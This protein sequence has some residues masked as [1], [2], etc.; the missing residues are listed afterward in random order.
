MQTQ[1]Q[2]HMQAGVVL[3]K[4]LNFSPEYSTHWTVLYCCT[5]VLF[6]WVQYPLECFWVQCSLQRQLECGT[7]QPGVI[8]KKS[9]ELHISLGTLS[10]VLSYV[11]IASSSQFLQHVILHKIVS[12][13]PVD[14]IHGDRWDRHLGAIF[15]FSFS[16]ANLQYFFIFHLSGFHL[17][18]TY[19]HL[20]HWTLHWTG[21]MQWHN[22]KSSCTSTSYQVNARPSKIFLQH[23]GSTVE[24]IWGRVHIWGTS[25]AA[26]TCGRKLRF[27]N[28]CS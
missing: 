5:A 13:G 26:R 23:N 21:I 8:D 2:T 24:S 10:S 27:N 19:C 9:S 15:S 17:C 14:F 1:T 28:L 12:S 16:T 11:Q 22:V 25:C 3:S 4:P 6:Y 18:L 7:V 20:S